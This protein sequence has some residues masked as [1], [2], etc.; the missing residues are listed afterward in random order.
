[1]TN[2][3]KQEIRLIKLESLA[4]PKE[5]AKPKS[6]YDLKTKIK[7][8]ELSIVI[9]YLTNKLM[10]GCDIDPDLHF[11]LSNIKNLE[12]LNLKITKLLE[13]VNSRKYDENARHILYTLK[14]LIGRC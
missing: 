2:N 11:M 9:S 1:M 12:E 3:N 4:F 5:V 13:P 14:F 8:S 10:L 6:L 7:D